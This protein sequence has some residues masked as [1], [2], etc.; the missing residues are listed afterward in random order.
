MCAEHAESITP[1][2]S[3]QAACWMKSYQAPLHLHFILKGRH[4]EHLL[5][6]GLHR[7][8]VFPEDYTG[9]LSWKEAILK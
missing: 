7:P 6:S 2:R 8:Q 4:A 3:C 1:S 9:F 5:C